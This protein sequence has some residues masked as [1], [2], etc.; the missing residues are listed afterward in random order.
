[1]L[2]SSWWSAP[3]APRRRAPRRYRHPARRRPRAR[4]RPTEQPRRPPRS[5]CSRAAPTRSRAPSS[6]IGRARPGPADPE[7][8]PRL[9]A[10]ARAASRIA[11]RSAPP[12]IDVDRFARATAS[13]SRR[14]T[15]AARF[16]AS[17]RRHR[18]ARSPGSPRKGSRCAIPRRRL[19][20]RVSFA[21]T[22]AKP[23]GRLPHPDERRYL[24]G[25]ARRT[26]PWRSAP[27]IPTE[28]ADIVLAIH[29]TH[30]F[31]PR[32]AART[33][34]QR[35]ASRPRSATCP[36]AGTAPLRPSTASPRQTGPPIYDVSTISTIRASLGAP[37]IDGGRRHHRRRG[38]RG[39]RASRPRRLPYPVR[40][41]ARTRSR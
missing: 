15:Y 31:Y 41:R 24:V 34:T 17:D 27:A 20:A 3:L 18:C 28:L 35:S 2:C 36:D 33:Q 22:V 23:R 1:V 6:T 37:K 19:R 26:T 21:G 9:Q 12:L 40:P 39:D 8:L 7:P 14:R 29:N 5:P 4:Y 25:R 30:D 13:G 10:L 32:P 11:T 38:D 16:G